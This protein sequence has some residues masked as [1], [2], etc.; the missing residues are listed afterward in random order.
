M[1]EQ[2]YGDTAD[3]IAGEYNIPS[4]IFRS[5]INI[6]SGWNPRAKS[7]AG[8]IGLTQLMPVIYR[9]K[10]YLTFNP[11]NP[12][13]SMRTGARFLSDLYTKYGDWN[14]ALSHYNAGYNLDNGRA[15]ALKVLSGAGVDISKYADKIKP[16]LTPTLDKIGAD[17][18]A[19]MQ[20][21]ADST[22]DDTVLQQ[23]M[24][25]ILQWF[26]DRFKDSGRTILVTIL[27]LFLLYLGIKKM[28]R[29]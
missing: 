26:K 22:G 4:N 21:R 27:A 20:T 10:Q 13:D 7:S 8:A 6:E 12:E 9:S 19:I 3:Q 2:L 11:Y 17:K 18:K 1:S 23:K 16:S 15:Y 5:L 25:E 28:V 29:I 14:D 24:S